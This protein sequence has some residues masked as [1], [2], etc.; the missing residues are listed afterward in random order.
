M[1]GYLRTFQKNQHVR[2]NSPGLTHGNK[3]ETETE[4]VSPAH[5]ASAAPAQQSDSEEESKL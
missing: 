1:K 2:P 3:S 4:Q 5:T